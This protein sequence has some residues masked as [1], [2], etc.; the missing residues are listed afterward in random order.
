M[1]NYKDQINRINKLIASHSWLSKNE[2]K[3]LLVMMYASGSKSLG[4]SGDQLS[5]FMKNSLD[6][7]CLDKKENLQE[8]LTKI[9][10]KFPNNQL[11][12]NE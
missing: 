4:L 7:I 6:R 5:K 10:E 3:V 2:A 1:E 8:Y 11:L 9:K 12:L